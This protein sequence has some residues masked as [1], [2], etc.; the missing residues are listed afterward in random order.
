MHHTGVATGVREQKRRDLTA[1]GIAR[2]VIGAKLTAVGEKG[3]I[4]EKKEW[5]IC[6]KQGMVHRYTDTASNR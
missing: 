5:K 6:W 3:V 1:L 2:Q 4:V